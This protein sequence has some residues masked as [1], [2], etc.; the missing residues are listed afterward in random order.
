MHVFV[1]VKRHLVFTSSQF[2]LSHL[3]RCFI[4]KIGQLISSTIFETFLTSIS[5]DSL[6][7]SKHCTDNHSFF[8]F[9]NEAEL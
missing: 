2:T 9:E 7:V 4:L 6:S 3:T 8:H 5:E 1:Y